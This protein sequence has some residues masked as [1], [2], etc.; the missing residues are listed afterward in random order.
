MKRL[1]AI[2]R[3]FRQDRRG[4]I[5]IEFGILATVLLG[6]LFGGVEYG[7]YILTNQ[8]ADRATASVGDMISQ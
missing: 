5:S 6:M 2:L 8:K 4:V 7:R 3:S 1:S